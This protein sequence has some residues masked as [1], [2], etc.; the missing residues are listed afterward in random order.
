[1]GIIEDDELRE[2]F[3]IESQ[4]HIQALEKGLLRLEA[5]PSDKAVLEEVFREA[6]SL[7]GSARMVGVRNVELISHKIEDLL[8]AVRKGTA[9]ITSEM[10]DRICRALDGIK[11]LVSEAVT[12]LPSGVETNG[13]IELLEK[14]NPQKKT[15]D[16][17]AGAMPGS[18]LT[19]TTE[20][21]AS[22]NREYRIDTVRVDTARLDELATLTGELAVFRTRLHDRL[23]GIVEAAEVAAVLLKESLRSHGAS[24]GQNAATERIKGLGLAISRLKEAAYEDTSR[25]DPIAAGLDD[26]VKLLRLLPFSTLF[27]LFP[28]AVRDMAREAGKDV[29]LI[30]EGGETGAD[31]RIIEEMK[32]PLMHILRNS[33]THGIEDPA[34]REAVGK[35][36]TGKITLRALRTEANI[37]VEVKDDGRGLDI[38]GIKNAALKRKLVTEETLAGM[39][40]AGIKSLIFASGFSTSAFITE[41]AGRGVGLDVVRAN[42][43]RLK[44]AIEVESSPGAGCAFKIKLPATLATAKMLI[45]E[46]SGRRYALPMSNIYTSILAKPEDLL[47]MEGRQAINHA[48]V[49]VSIARL[50]QILELTDDNNAPAGA[51]TEKKAHPCVIISSGTDRLAVIVDELLDEQEVVLKQ[52]GGLL[53]RVRNVSGTT[54]LGSGEVCIILNP[55]DMIKTVHKRHAQAVSKPEAAKTD[56]GKKA[57]LLVEDS[58]TTRTQEKRILEG[59]GYEVVVAV[60]GLDAMSLISTQRFDVV[61]SDIMMPNMDGLALTARIRQDARYKDIPIVLVTTLA[62][63]EDKK[64]GLEAGANAYIPKPSFDQK[65]FIETLAR[66]I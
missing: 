53:K 35:P 26:G 6:H 19:T 64:R 44:G 32:D 60:D 22:H 29:A 66:L 18:P 37:V 38:E 2:L 33:V 7:K 65:I 5:D 55:S 52:S 12:G 39:N 16:V 45:V 47:L 31:K 50:A 56:E 25:L 43:D 11:G 14:G 24:T 62:S 61:V 41:T 8:G 42:V 59:A 13:I 30:I 57:V 3:K 40:E 34:E 49:C 58:I 48:G 9:S 17:Q 63:D 36:R 23:K 4:E 46:E 51:K 10:V 20:D 28:M 21:S 54:I 15:S 27:N 1:M